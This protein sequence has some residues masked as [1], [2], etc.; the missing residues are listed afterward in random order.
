MT[1]VGQKFAKTIL[2]LVLAVLLVSCTLSPVYA[3]GS[4]SGTVII[5]GGGNAPVVLGLW[6]QDASL[7]L[8]DG[9]SSHAQTGA[10]FLPPC[11]NGVFKKISFYVIV[12]DE[13]SMGNLQ[14]VSVD[15]RNR[16]SSYHGMVLCEQLSRAEGNSALQKAAAANLI[17]YKPQVTTEQAVSLVRG[18]IA[19]VWKGEI[20]VPY[21]QS[22]GTFVVTATGIDQNNNYS[23]PLKNSFLYCSVACMSFDFMSV[24]YGSVALGREKI[25]PGDEQFGT[26]NKPTA[27]NIG[28]APAKILVRQDDMG[29][30]KNS[31]GVWNVGYGVRVGN[32]ENILRFDPFELKRTADAINP[33]E[34]KSLDF[35]INVANGKGSHSG[36]MSLAYIPVELPPQPGSDDPD[37]PG[38]PDMPVPEFPS[39]A[40]VYEFLKSLCDSIV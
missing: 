31:D 35:T 12:T 26:H 3:A 28:N 14:T 10:Q 11:K 17:R 6:E 15:F 21:D 1:A 27:Q 16:N 23:Q 25:I 7:S 38:D 5:G 19:S 20:S 30:G 39:P 40:C 9:D 22:A 36:Y 32:S 4:S 29:L 33:G 37:V 18:G 2:M 8:E 34:T 24:D 13:E